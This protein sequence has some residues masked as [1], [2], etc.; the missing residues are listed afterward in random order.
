MIK[1][2]V[3]SLT[4]H[5]RLK[6]TQSNKCSLDKEEAPKWTILWIRK[7]RKRKIHSGKDKDKIT[8]EAYKISRKMRIINKVVPAEINLIVILLKLNPSIHQ[9]KIKNN[10][11]L[12]INKKPSKEK[13]N[14]NICEKLEQPPQKRAH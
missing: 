10:S 9:S 13:S 4:H 6:I 14:N 7:N 12:L 2:Q 5:W 1:V 3:N 8:L 11:Q